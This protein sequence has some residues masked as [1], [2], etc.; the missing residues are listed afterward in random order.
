MQKRVARG[1]P[2]SYLHDETQDVA[3]EWGAERT[4]EFYLLDSNKIVIY[5]GRMDDSP[6]NPM[7]ATTTELL[8]AINALISNEN[9]L[10]NSTKSIG[11]SVKW[12]V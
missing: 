1:M 10:V 6:K 12:K 9:P 4:P 3:K 5:R 8:D 7:H 2:Y 11:C